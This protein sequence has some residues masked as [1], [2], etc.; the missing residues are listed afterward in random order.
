MPKGGW[1]SVAHARRRRTASSRRWPTPAPASPA[2]TSRASTIRSSP[3]RRSARAP[4]SASR[5]P[6]ASCASTT[7][8]STA[9]ASSGR[10]PGSS[11]EFPVGAGRTGG[12]RGAAHVGSLTGS[13][14]V[15]TCGVTVPFWSSTT[16]RSC[17]RS[18][19]RCS[20][21]RATTCASPPRGAEGIELAKSVPFDAAI[22][23][24]MMPGMDGIATLDE[25]K[26]LDD[27]LPVLMITAFASV[28]TRD[29]GD[30]ARRVRL[31]H[32][33]VQERRSAGRRAQRRRAAPAD[34]REHGAAAEPAGAVAEVRRH[35]RPQP[36][37]EA[38]V[39]PDHPGGAEPLDDPDHRRERHRQG[40]G[41]ARDSRQLAARGPR[42]RHGELRQPA[43]RPARVDAVR[44]R[45][46]RVHRRGLSRRRGSATSPTRAASSST[47][48]ATSRSRRRPSCCA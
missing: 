10:A 42:V 13:G 21:A 8:R 38:G 28:E 37:D 4:A 20:R 17:A 35:H 41:R 11:L 3:P 31:H 25:L 14:R 34:G 12:A 44:P 9:T 29:R 1:L 36:A 32:Q 46:G 39:R 26:K 16:K 15:C 43:A 18:S 7:A 47:R 27:E 23:D 22:V 30:E 19:R 48:S 33:A 2:S 5:S 6:T 24:V 45:E 40:A